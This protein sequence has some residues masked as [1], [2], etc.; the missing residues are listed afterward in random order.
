[1]RCLMLWGYAVAVL[2]VLWLVLLRPS[3]WY[4]LIE[5]IGNVAAVEYALDT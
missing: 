1:M 4:E 3:G 5:W 2:S